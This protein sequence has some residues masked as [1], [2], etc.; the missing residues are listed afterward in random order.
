MS[1]LT[2]KLLIPE[3]RWTCGCGRSWHFALWCFECRY[4]HPLG[5][6]KPRRITDAE[7]AVRLPLL[8]A[9]HGPARRG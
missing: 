1:D 2:D 9:R 3:Y 7:F 4:A 5:P 8:M 6:G